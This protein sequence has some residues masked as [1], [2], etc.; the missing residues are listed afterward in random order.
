MPTCPMRAVDLAVCVVTSSSFGYQERNES[1]TSNNYEA[2]RDDVDQYLPLCLHRL[3]FNEQRTR[4]TFRSITLNPS[5]NNSPFSGSPFGVLQVSSFHLR[6][7]NL[8]D[9]VLEMLFGGVR[10]A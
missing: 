2:I 10:V 7:V 4:L 5:L 1:D 8:V 9:H 3:D 6:V